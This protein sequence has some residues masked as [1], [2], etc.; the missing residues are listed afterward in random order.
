MF[1][2]Q[3][4]QWDA[5]SSAPAGSV[6]ATAS[7]NTQPAAINTLTLLPDSLGPRI[8]KFCSVAKSAAERGPGKTGVYKDKH[9]WVSMV[10]LPSVLPISTSTEVNTQPTTSSPTLLETVTSGN[11]CAKLFYVGR[12]D[13][14]EE[15]GM[16]LKK[17]RREIAVTGGFAYKRPVSNMNSFVQSYS[18]NLNSTTPTNQRQQGSA[19]PSEQAGAAG[20]NFSSAPLPSPL[21]V[22]SQSAATRKV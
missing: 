5:N 18:A 10:S 4:I 17:A 8:S 16:A 15:A 6:Q 19:V 20:G 14:E 3:S 21:K 9:K 7:Q 12:Y 22:P 2:G 13:T 1:A 11:E